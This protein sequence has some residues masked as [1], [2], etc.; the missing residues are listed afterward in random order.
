MLEMIVWV[1]LVA[2]GLGVGV[3]AIAGGIGAGAEVVS[4]YLFRRQLRRKD[5]LTH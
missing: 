4:G 1:V 5:R 2:A 3:F